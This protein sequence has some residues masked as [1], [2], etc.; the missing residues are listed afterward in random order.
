VQTVPAAI[1]NN[2]RDGVFAYG[3]VLSP[4]SGDSWS[5]Y[6]WGE[7]YLAIDNIPFIPGRLMGISRI[8]TKAEIRAGGAGVTKD[9]VRVEL[10]NT[11][12]YHEQ[13]I[14][15]N[16]LGRQLQI[17]LAPISWNQI[18]NGS[19]ERYTG[20]NFD[21]WT[22]N[23]PGAGSD[24]LP[25][26]S[27]KTH[28]AASCFMYYDGVAPAPEIYSNTF[29][30][31]AGEY[32]SVSLDA[33]GAGAGDKFKI[34]ISIGGFYWKWSTRTLQLGA[35]WKEFTTTT[36]W[37]R[38]PIESLHWSELGLSAA[39]VTVKIHIKVDTTGD[40]VLFDAVQA[41]AHPNQRPYI[42]YI[43]DLLSTDVMPVY[44]GQVRDYSW[45]K[46]I[47]TIQTNSILDEAH[48]DIPVT[49]CTNAIDADW[50]IPPDV[51]GKP[52]PM[53]YGELN[54]DPNLPDRRRDSNN[55]F[56]AGL[57]VNHLD[58]VD[59]VT[60]Y[61]DRP[62]MKLYA[63][64]KVLHFNEDSNQFYQ[65]LYDDRTSPIY[66]AYEWDKDANNAKVSANASAGFLPA[67]Q[68]PLSICIRGLIVRAGTVLYPE[69]AIDNDT[70][71]Y[72]FDNAGSGYADYHFERLGLQSGNI[73]DVFGLMDAQAYAGDTWRLGILR[74]ASPAFAIYRNIFT[75]AATF[76]NC[77][78]S[79]SAKTAKET[80]HSLFSP[81]SGSVFEGMKQLEFW[82]APSDDILYRLVIQGSVVGSNYCYEHGFRIDASI[83][84]LSA[85]ICGAVR[86]REWQD[87]WGGR[88]TAGSLIQY[89]ADVI[90]SILRDELGAPGASINTDSFDA[91][92]SGYGSYDYEVWIAGQQ[93][94]IRNSEEVID[95]ICR[96]SGLMYYLDMNGK[97]ALRRLGYASSAFSLREGDF[98]R[99]SIKIGYTERNQVVNSY[100]LRYDK[101]PIT[102]D[103]SKMVY[104]NRSASNF[105]VAGDRTEY[106]GKCAASY[107]A[108]G[109]VE[110]AAEFE[111]PWIH[112]K[113]YAENLL[114]WLIDWNYLQRITVTGKIFMDKIGIEI[115]DC[116]TLELP[117]YLPETVWGSSR[118]VVESVKIEGGG[119]Q[120][121]GLLEVKNPA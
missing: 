96:C 74:T 41:E 12:R 31:K 70:S 118:F 6:R 86:G 55:D 75:G 121:I 66:T 24:I 78:W 84:I 67:G 10:V 46:S 2:A 61:F 52:F 87:S 92:N 109:D 26:T 105:D 48:K 18:G 11:D 91:V 36:S 88:R 69:R 22:E 80:D 25:T 54:G 106:E 60:A 35:D 32:L 37:A 94:A 63:I 112:V 117:H 19:F 68:F 56:A 3:V 93:I 113:E 82:A 71:T 5:A 101:N 39:Y 47:L 42:P 89:P 43:F 120:S 73:I 103:Y 29:A 50:V 34:A 90:E 77:P 85:V 72:A 38:F 13:F 110:Y 20:S 17:Y 108:L 28:G 98:E 7:K 119:V 53:T 51:A 79:T 81:S 57:L 111:A 76:N 95:E 30:V 97:H 62:G 33:R 21:Y 23:A 102:G 45:D 1:A 104:C 16:I 40:G 65:E 8:S 115:G 15:D 4:R 27:Q 49:L 64:N 58:G 100:V 9:S 99:D 83:D 107:A 114:Q 14:T 44:L 59:P 116:G